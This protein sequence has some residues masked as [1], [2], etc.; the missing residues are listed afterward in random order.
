MLFLDTSALVKRYVQEPGSEFV[1]EVMAQDGDW[2]AS[3]LARAEGSI[4]LC[5]RGFDPDTLADVQR[6]LDED[7]QRIRVVPLDAECLSL[8]V[9][10]GCAYRLRTLDAV[11]LAAA[12]RLPDPFR[13]LTFDYRQVA[14]AIGL[15]MV[16]HSTSDRDGILDSAPATGSGLEQPDGTVE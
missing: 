6:Q 11:H 16:V 1:A 13:V 3:A 7:W 5:Q 10:L 9:E 14:G 12:R 15:G 8:A 2:V 4:T